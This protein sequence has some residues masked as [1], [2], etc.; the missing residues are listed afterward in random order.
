MTTISLEHAIRL[1]SSRRMC[2]Y[3]C[4]CTHRESRHFPFNFV[5][6]ISNY[7]IRV[8]FNV[9][10]TFPF[11]IAMPEDFSPVLLFI[12]NWMN[13]YNT[14]RVYRVK[15]EKYQKSGSY[16]MSYIATY[17]RMESQ[18]WNLAEMFKLIVTYYTVY[19]MSLNS[20]EVGVSILE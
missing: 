17:N 5:V 8:Y 12:C 14:T 7:I 2:Y 16:D 3:K 4:T 19:V 20:K 13:C 10:R 18:F 1:T 6:L 15:I 9:N 11:S